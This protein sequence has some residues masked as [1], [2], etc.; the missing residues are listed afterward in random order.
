MCFDAKTSF[1]TGIFTVICCHLLIRSTNNRYALDNKKIGYIFIYISLVQFLE[2]FMWLDEGCRG[3]S[4]RL[5]TSLIRYLVYF[6]PILVY[7]VAGDRSN[8]R[9]RLLV[10]ILY[11]I[12][13]VFLISSSKLKGCSV[14]N[15][16]G[17][18][19]WNSQL[20]YLVAL[21][22]PYFALLAWNIYGGLSPPMGVITIIILIISLSVSRIFFGYS[23][24][25]M[26]CFLSCLI[27]LVIFFITRW[28]PKRAGDTVDKVL[29]LPIDDVGNS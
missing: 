18:L 24:G 29:P 6:Q 4:N 11:G 13:V 16:E 12:W 22:I 10:N 19:N 7:L 8:S 28:L 2:G 23:V 26:W 14:P 9:F 1:V 25:E 21:Q 3:S 17:H 15:R 20:Q 27:P 5:A